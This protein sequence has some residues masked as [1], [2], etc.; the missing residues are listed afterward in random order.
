MNWQ[1]ANQFLRPSFRRS[2][3]HWSPG[4]LDK[5]DGGFFNSSS[6][7]QFHCWK[8]IAAEL[9]LVTQAVWR[10]TLQITCRYIFCNTGRVTCTFPNLQ[11]S[12]GRSISEV[13]CGFPDNLDE[14]NAQDVWHALSQIGGVLR[15]IHYRHPLHQS[16]FPSFFPVLYTVIKTWGSVDDFGALALCFGTQINFFAILLQ[17][18]V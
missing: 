3:S 16:L 1:W 2:A 18:H 4:L 6:H 9:C 14:A 12:A 8:R 13:I 17:G 5:H 15:P 7:L 10:A 11:H